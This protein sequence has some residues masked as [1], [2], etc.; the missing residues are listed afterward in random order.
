MCEPPPWPQNP[1]TAYPQPEP[2]AGHD[3]KMPGLSRVPNSQQI[4]AAM[5]GAIPDLLMLV[6]K[7]GTYVEFLSS[8]DVELYRQG[9]EFDLM[10]IHDCLPAPLAEERLSLIQTALQSGHLQSHEYAIEIQGQLFYEE[11]RIMPVDAD[12]AMVMVRDVTTSKL[13]AMQLKAKARQEHILY[14][15]LGKISKSADLQDIFDFTVAEVKPFLKADRVLFYRFEPDWS[16][17][18]MAEA[19]SSPW[20]VLQGSH[21]KDHCLAQEDYIDAY[22]S[23]RIHKIDDLNQS[24]ISPC[25]RELLNQWQVQANL[26]IPVKRGEELHGLFAAQHCQCSHQWATWEEEFLLKVAEHLANAIHQNELYQKLQV[27]NAELE[28]LATTD[29]LTQVANRL[30]F[31]SFLTREWFRMRREQL[32]LTLILFDIDYFKQFNDCYGHMEGDACLVKVATAA[33]NALKRPADFI[34]R[35]GGEEFALLLP[36][37]DAEGAVAV[38]EAVRQA[39]FNLQIPHLKSHL[40]D[41]VVTISLGVTCT[42]P[43]PSAQ[44]TQLLLEADQAL[45]QA[46]QLGRNRCCLF[47]SS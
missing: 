9:H 47:S 5:L 28:R 40:Q 13:M 42:L 25:H 39:V 46:K 38:A 35:Y 16:G 41:R 23:G 27:A 34:A 20:P 43:T 10:N 33:R 31:D 7:D 24:D 30:R 29:S 32:P 17:V 21:V 8:G 14:T 6:K 19:V 11:A 4:Q 18:I 22:I 45:Y 3:N 15:I 36:N 37:T 26:L 44:S 1:E 2:S 12:T